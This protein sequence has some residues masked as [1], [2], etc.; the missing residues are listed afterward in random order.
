M[1][2]NITLCEKCRSLSSF[3]S[4]FNQYVCTQC[5]HHQHGEFPSKNSFVDS[6]KKIPFM[7]NNLDFD[8]GGCKIFDTRRDAVQFTQH[9]VKNSAWNAAW[10]AA[11][12]AALRVARDEKEDASSDAAGHVKSESAKSTVMASARY[13]IARSMLHEAYRPI[14]EP[15]MDI[16][17]YAVLHYL[18]TNLPI[19]QEHR[20]YIDKRC[21][22]WKNGY[23][24]LCDID[25]TLYVYRKDI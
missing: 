2:D 24:V 13:S 8:L 17:L 20:D 22:I 11:M 4:Y 9:I 19:L 3:D 21:A 6:I 23:G 15:S 12:F 14:G 7:Q 5:R 10:L 25:G 18:C 1:C 16:A